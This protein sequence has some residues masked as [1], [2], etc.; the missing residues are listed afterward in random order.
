VVNSSTNR[1]GSTSF[2]SVFSNTTQS[3]SSSAF[4][5]VA[6]NP[7]LEAGYESRQ[8]QSAIWINVSSAGYGSNL[9]SGSAELTDLLGGLLLNATGNLT[10]NLLN[11]SAELPTL[12]LSSNVLSALATFAGRAGRVTA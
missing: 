1:P 3:G 12:G 10:G 9:T 7:A 2:I 4:G 5:G 6:S 8:V 11:E